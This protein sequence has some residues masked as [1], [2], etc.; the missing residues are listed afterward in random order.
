MGAL[1]FKAGIGTSSR[2]LAGDHEDATVGVLV[3]SNFGGRLTV[4]GVDLADAFK[5]PLRSPAT[6]R[7]PPAKFIPMPTG[8]RS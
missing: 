3:Q 2:R 7:T 6:L 1:G 8:H 5:D 4:A